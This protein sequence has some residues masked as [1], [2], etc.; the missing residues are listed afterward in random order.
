[1][2][3]TKPKRNYSRNPG[4]ANNG[5]DVNGMKGQQTNTKGKN[6]NMQQGSRFATLSDNTSDDGGQIREENVREENE[7]ESQ[8]QGAIRSGHAK[9]KRPTTQVLE[10]QIMGNN[11]H[12]KHRSQPEAGESSTR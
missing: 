5:G 9:G 3:A 12:G 1:M 10:K 7:K 4:N 6:S 11:K 2:V 8:N